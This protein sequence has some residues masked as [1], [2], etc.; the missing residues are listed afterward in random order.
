MPKAYEYILKINDSQAKS[1]I[2][3]FAKDIGIV[4]NKFGKLGKSAGLDQM[5]RGLKNSQLAVGSLQG[6]IE[7]LTARRDWTTSR[8]KIALYNSEIQK[9]QKE[10]DKLSGKQT[11]VFGSLGGQIAGFVGIG[12]GISLFGNIIK[13]G[14]QLEQTKI[15]FETM[16]GSASKATALLGDLDKFANVTP[17]AN[18]DLQ[19]NA[20]LLLNF[21]TAQD[22]IIPT[23]KSIGDISGGNKE[24]LNG[25]TLAYAQTQSAGKLM[26]Q[27]LMQMIN[28][29]FNPLQ[30][31]SKTTGKSIGQLKDEM[32]K[33]AISAAMVE[34]AF[35][36][37]TGPGG[38]F[39]GMMEKQSKSFSGRLST[40]TGIAQSL[41]GKIGEAINPVL[42]LF[43]DLGIKLVQ[44][45]N[46]LKTIGVVVAIGTAAFLAYKAVLL[47][48]GIYTSILTISQI[49]LNLAMIGNPIGLVVAGFV[50]LIG[51]TI[52]AWNKFEG[53]R[54]AVFGVWEV[55]KE[56][57]NNITTK[58]KE[59][60]GVIWEAI[61]GIPRAFIN[62]F[63]DVGGIIKAVL[64]G[65]FKAIPDLLKS[66]GTN[67]LKANPM[68]AVGLAVGGKLAEGTSS[69]WARGMKKGANKSNQLAMPSMLGGTSSDSDVSS[70]SATTTPTDGTDQIAGKGGRQINVTVNLGKFLDNIV[71]NPASMSEGVSDIENQLKEMFVRLLNGGLHAATQ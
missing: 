8:K 24:K 14:A 50:A 56:V 35:K 36:D 46:L 4:E 37:A 52:W 63:K 54:G 30:Q 5:S 40:L 7:R 33:G 9:A 31:M 16:L 47:V 39:F 21:G 25:L 34:Q 48:S 1:S 43:V 68:T 58:F 28:Q 29:G 27:D 32:S 57:Y 3:N 11:S 61:Q 44:N 66:A 69:A 20:Q 70:S 42:G 26:G 15:S 67:L 55:L 23:L 71:I 2:K 41:M 45:E 6:K 18:A 17:F 13:E 64:T 62:A 38:Q 65:D 53:F 59:L 60:P 49:K 10:V 51:V 19:K 22:K 12:A